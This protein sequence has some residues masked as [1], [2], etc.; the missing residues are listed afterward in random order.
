M[1]IKNLK[2]LTIPT[3]LKIDIATAYKN[4]K[5]NMFDN[6]DYEI[7]AQPS[8]NAQSTPDLLKQDLLKFVTKLNNQF[9]I[10]MFSLS[11]N[12]E[13]WRNAHVYKIMCGKSYVASI[14]IR[15]DENKDLDFICVAYKT[16]YSMFA[17]LKEND[18]KN[19]WQTSFFTLFDNIPNLLTQTTKSAMNFNNDPNVSNIEPAYNPAYILKQLDDNLNFFYLSYYVVLTYEVFNVIAP[20]TNTISARAISALENNSATNPNWLKNK[21][22]ALIKDQTDNFIKKNDTIN[23]KLVPFY[24]DAFS[25][26]QYL[27]STRIVFLYNHYSQTINLN[28]LNYATNYLPF[29]QTYLK[30]TNKITDSQ[31][32]YDFLNL[33]NYLPIYNE[34]Q[35]LSYFNWT[36]DGIF[37]GSFE[38]GSIINNIEPYFI[39]N[40]PSFSYPGEFEIRML[41]PN[42]NTRHFT[43]YLSYLDAVSFIYL[44][45]QSIQNTPWLKEELDTIPN[46]FIDKAQMQDIIKNNLHLFILMFFNQ[47]NVIPHIF[48]PKTILSK[49][50]F[51]FQTPT[52]PKLLTNFDVSYSIDVDKQYLAKT[53]TTKEERNSSFDSYFA[54]RVNLNRSLIVNNLKESVTTLVTRMSDLTYRTVFQAGT[55]ISTNVHFSSFFHSYIFEKVR[56]VLG[57]LDYL[58]TLRY[59][60]YYL[61]HI[62]NYG[63]Y[64]HGRYE[65]NGII[66]EVFVNNESDYSLCIK[67]NLSPYRNKEENLIDGFKVESVLKEQNQI[68]QALFQPNNTFLTDLINGFIDAYGKLADNINNNDDTTRVSLDIDEAV[69]KAF[70]EYVDYKKANKTWA[71]YDKDILSALTKKMTDREKQTFNYVWPDK[72]HYNRPPF[73]NSMSNYMWSNNSHLTEIT[74]SHPL[75]YKINAYI[76]YFLEE[77]PNEQAIMN[78]FNLNY[79]AELAFIMKQQGFNNL[80]RNSSWTSSI[81][82]CDEDLKDLMEE[83]GYVKVSDAYT[84]AKQFQKD[85]ST[86]YMNNL[87]EINHNFALIDEA[88]HK[89]QITKTKQ[90]EAISKSRLK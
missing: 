66:T 15:H 64:L 59:F 86:Q 65:K 75:N 71:Q 70:L 1:K 63:I 47:L 78:F 22:E 27:L 4:R 16:D 24:L 62:I 25:N 8:L 52:L 87:T 39:M 77:N 57:D 68:I 58:T 83:L 85:M 44:C 46:Q 17:K 30:G 6:N 23:A 69:Q 29:S 72:C 9:T 40:T 18:T 45:E 79:G 48:N 33:R 10:P 12:N 80:L 82:M 11:Y 74:D 21:I 43:T 89:D 76:D 55:S 26:R 90:Q 20:T 60:Y 88:I 81:R 67:T 51:K 2:H 73:T 53:N 13:K 36:Y 19:K 31:I 28:D 32:N 34:V 54:N 50:Y 37:A 5:L 42:N 3:D 84:T 49:N 61:Q 38:C 56:K 41:D 35:D 14:E 7:F